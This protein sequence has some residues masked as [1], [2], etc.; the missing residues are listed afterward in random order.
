M[1]EK[2]ATPIKTKPNSGNKP[3]APE[4]AAIATQK[5]LSTVVRLKRE[6]N[7]RF[8]AGQLIVLLASIWLLW[9]FWAYP[10]L[11]ASTSASDVMRRTEQ[12]VGD[13]E[14]GLVAWKE[15]NLLLLDKPATDFGFLKPWHEQLGASIRWIER[16]LRSRSS[17]E[18]S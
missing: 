5:L 8:G 1:I 12:L 4:P 11:N 18:M 6:R 7:Q 16:L 13:G 2:T 9:G 17:R 15:Q 10:V 3:G 14:L